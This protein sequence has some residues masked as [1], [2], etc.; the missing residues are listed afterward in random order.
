[1][2]ST[3]VYQSADF[4]RWERAT[5][6]PLHASRAAGMVECLDLFLVLERG[7]NVM[8]DASASGDGDGVRHVLK[9]SVM[10]TLQDY[11]VVGRY[12]DAAD[13]FVPAEPERGDD[14]RAWRRLDYG[15]VYASK[16]FFD[17]RHGRRVL[18]AW[19]NESDSQADDVAKGWS[20]VQV[21]RR[22]A[23]LLRSVYTLTHCSLACAT[24][25]DVPEEAVA[26]RGR[27]AA[28]AVA[29]GGDRDAAEGASG[30]AAGGDR[31]RRP[32]RDRRRRQPTGGRGVRVRGPEP[33]GS[34]FF[35][36]LGVNF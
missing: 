31:L 19:A 29:G 27:E 20:G 33:G 4:L 32:A 35:D 17:E 11:Y 1:M 7:D 30:A 16:T 25:A 15:H 9:L 23:C 28:A 26:G 10:D 6:A 12:D 24:Y 5:T 14:V 21:P 8:L 3:L 34:N 18:W 36:I 2:A 22:H 13:A